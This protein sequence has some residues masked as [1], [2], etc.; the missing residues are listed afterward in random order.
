MRRG[1]GGFTLI[2]L[3]VVIGL[4]GVITSLGIQ[5]FSSMSARWNGA[6]ARADMQLRADL[7]FDS[8]R[9]DV[10]RVPAY[11][12]SGQG[13]RADSGTARDDNAF[14]GMVLENDQLVV[15]VPDA[16]NPERVLLV[17]YYIERPPSVPPRLMRVAFFD[18]Q[19]SR[20]SLAEGVVSMAVQCRP[21]HGAP[22]QRAWNGERVPAQ[23]AVSVVMS[24][25]DNPAEQIARREVVTIHA[26]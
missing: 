9:R 22:W 12:F 13:V 4:L 2:E 16:N 24:D 3:V 23:I 10:S 14:W 18:G 7:I 26:R 19:V 1:R 15:P 21:E 17:R 5:A 25:P 6:K 11:A 20:V 8:I